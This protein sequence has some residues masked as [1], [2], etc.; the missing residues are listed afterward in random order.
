MIK[1]FFIILFITIIIF[2]N[3]NCSY[4]TYYDDL[5]NYKTDPIQYIKLWQDNLQAS[6]FNIV[7][8]QIGNKTVDELEGDFHDFV[9]DLINDTRYFYVVYQNNNYYVFM[10]NSGSK[11]NDGYEGSIDISLNQSSIATVPTILHK[12]SGYA[13]F[14]CYIINPSPSEFSCTSDMVSGSKSPSI[15]DSLIFYNSQSLLSFRDFMAGNDISKI[16]G[17]IQENTQIQQETNQKLQEQNDFL[18]EDIN[19]SEIDST[20]P[21]IDSNTDVTSSGVD[22]IFTAI[23]NGINNNNPIQFSILGNNVTIDKDMLADNLPSSLTSIIGLFWWF[24]ISYR[25]FK[26]IINIFEKVTTGE[27]DKVDTTN[28][29]AD[30]F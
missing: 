1:K 13:I 6:L 7:I 22:S 15:P 2:C 20:L 19:D 9:N 25:I 28:V 18:Q 29:K 27:I 4:A 12:M 8:N 3:I 16:A 26:D 5:N 23:K 10:Y 24:F 21:S 17:A 30:L 14:H 11:F